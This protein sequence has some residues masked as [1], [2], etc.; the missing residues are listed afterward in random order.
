MIT[1]EI[2]DKKKNN[3]LLH[4]LLDWFFPPACAGCGRIGF[5]LCP[6]CAAGFEKGFEKAQTAQ[7]NERRYYT[8]L[9]ADEGER[10]LTELAFLGLHQDELAQAVRELKYHQNDAIGPV[11]G[12]LL[13]EAFF[14]LGWQ[15]DVVMPVPLG[16]KRLRRRGYNQA[17]LI[18][19]GFCAQSD[20]P[21]A[22]DCLTR[23]K[24]T[25]SQV[26]LDITQREVNMQ[27]A[28]IAEG[29]LINGKQILLIDDVL[30]TGATLRSCA[31]AL[32]EGGAASVMAMTITSATV[33]HQ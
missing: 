2:S 20:L 31:A 21:L 27:N 9:K 30:T 11:L 29:S 26:G 28:F 6:E 14:N 1:E 5:L 8:G 13:A 10:L 17:E 3:T 7:K 23:K 22:C 18:A 4:V 12:E 25:R 19:R 24:E 32:L 16:E 33:A 15:V